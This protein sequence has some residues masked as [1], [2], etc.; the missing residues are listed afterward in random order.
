MNFD[1]MIIL[2]AGT[3]LIISFVAIS[4]AAG[5]YFGRSAQRLVD[6]RH[7]SVR[8]KAEVLRRT[9]EME[10]TWYRHWK[11]INAAGKV[12]SLQTA[13]PESVPSADV[14]YLKSITRV[15]DDQR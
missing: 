6:I 4:Y 3:V 15:P 14:H 8:E 5:R 1:L 12:E 10:S 9:Q 13:R 7:Q 2:I 11:D